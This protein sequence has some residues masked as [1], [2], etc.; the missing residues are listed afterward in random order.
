MRIILGLLFILNV[1]TL[2]IFTAYAPRSLPCNYFC[3]V[4]VLFAVNILA[5]AVLFC[6]LTSN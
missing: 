1:V 2:T 4:L 5:N 3:T 6:L